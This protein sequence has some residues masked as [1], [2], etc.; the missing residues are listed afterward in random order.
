MDFSFYLFY[1][2]FLHINLSAYG[3][4]ISTVWIRYR[5]IVLKLKKKKISHK[6]KQFKNNG[7]TSP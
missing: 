2:F 3:D 6:K 4:D 1:F 5:S 7:F